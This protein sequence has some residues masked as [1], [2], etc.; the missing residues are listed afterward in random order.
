MNR[1]QDISVNNFK[2]GRR[3]FRDVKYPDIPLQSSDIYVISSFGDRYDLVAYDYYKDDTLWWIVAVAN[4]L[5]RDSI[6]IPQG[7]QLRIPTDVGDVIQSYN[8]L[9]TNP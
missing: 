1:Y 9:N 7:T 5:P 4:D 3:Y 6:Y 2:D 8:T